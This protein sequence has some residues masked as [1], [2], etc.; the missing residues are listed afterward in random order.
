MDPHDEEELR[1]LIRKELESREKLRT[2]RST[3]ASRPGWSDERKQIIEQEIESFYGERGGHRRW[4]N[5]D[6]E[7]EWLTEEEIREREQQVPVDIEE[8]EVGQRRVRT[9]LLA[10]IVLAFCTIGLLIV[11]MR[12]RTGSIQVICNVPQAV[13]VLNGSPTEFVTDHRLQNLRVGPQVI[14]VRKPGYVPDGRSSVRID[15]RAGA[16]E[17][18]ILRLKPGITDSLGRP[19]ED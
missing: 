6:G 16:G 8:L 4:E 11:L 15:L 14:S 12:E 18:A 3:A 7:V 5:E 2:I 19:K 1:R 17:I 13:I 9:R 10:L